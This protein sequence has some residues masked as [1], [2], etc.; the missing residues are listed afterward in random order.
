MQKIRPVRNPKTGK[1]QYY[2]DGNALFTFNAAAANQA[3]ELIGK[4][5]DIGA[6]KERLEV[7][8]GPSLIERLQAGRDRARMKRSGGAEAMCSPWGGQRPPRPL[9]S[10]M[11]STASE[12]CWQDWGKRHDEPVRAFV[13]I[14]RETK[15]V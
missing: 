11:A 13:E 3:L 4:H 8:S 7:S 6:F 12:K 14:V 2:D 15:L 10:P 5:V 9:C 1:Q